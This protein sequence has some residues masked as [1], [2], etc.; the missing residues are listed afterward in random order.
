MS[1]ENLAKEENR[2]Y[3]V[4]IGMDPR[5]LVRKSKFLSLVLRHRPET[6]GIVLDEA[7]WADVAALLDGCAGAG[8]PL[9]GEEL[10]EV[11]A[12]ND[13][14]R[15]E[16]SADGL[17]I[18]ASQGHSVA[19]D[20]GYRPAAPPEV[21][22]H[23][24]SETALPSIRRRG[25]LRGKRHDV[26]LHVDRDLALRVGGRHGRPVLLTV[27]AGAMHAAGH[28][29]R[30]STNGVWLVEAVPP[31]YINFPEAAAKRR[32]RDPAPCHIDHLVV[33]APSL[34]AGAEH[35]ERALGVQLQKGGEHQRM[36]THNLLLRLGDSLYLEVIAP[37][38]AA[39]RPSRPR[40]F[41]LDGP[42]AADSPRLATWIA[43]TTDIHRAIAELPVQLGH[44]ESM[45]RGELRWLITIPSDGSLPLGGAAPALIEWQVPVH[46][47][48]RMEEQGCSLQRLE[49]FHPEPERVATLLG[50]LGL[51]PRVPVRALP[52]GAS[53]F[54]VAQ[55]CSPDGVRSI[56][57][58]H[59][60]R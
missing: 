45:S 23:G 56:G 59:Q 53:P 48:S 20:L 39:P 52:P 54:L 30:L 46:P 18:R 43:R 5:D 2:A 40:W 26:H 38:P 31:G 50:Q 34:E 14:K 7:G 55:I 33:T 58:P 49:V 24:T 60:T 35:V 9:S 57:G 28:V 21:L 37:D 44:I 3:N 36:G 17:R 27:Q 25:L 42:W 41:E 15:F 32:E 8:R 4:R 51:A 16:L 22:H 29:F 6:V 11:V 12:T 19:V 13:K 1:G 47:A 10:R